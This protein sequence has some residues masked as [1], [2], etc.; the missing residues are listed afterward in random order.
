MNVSPPLPLLISEIVSEHIPSEVWKLLK[1][2]VFHS[3]WD[4][5]SGKPYVG[6]AGL[7][8]APDS[9]RLLAGGWRRSGHGLRV[10]DR[11][12][13]ETKITQR[14][15]GDGGSDLAPPY[16]GGKGRRLAS[17]L[18]SERGCDIL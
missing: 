18:L 13:V 9:C 2:L 5:V 3:V 12:L 4:F 15:G 16:Y 8:L 7:A 10:T 14:R 6:S 11:V 1:L 17:G